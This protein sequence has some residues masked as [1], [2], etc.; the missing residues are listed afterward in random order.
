MPC[1]GH[2]LPE[3]TLHQAG[4]VHVNAL[5]PIVGH[6]CEK[7]AHKDDKQLSVRSVSN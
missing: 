7:Q 5:R 2:L 4:T 3:E 6:L 1:K